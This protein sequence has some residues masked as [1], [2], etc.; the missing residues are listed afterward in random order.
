MSKKKIIG[1]TAAAIVAVI[2]IAAGAIFFLRATPSEARETALVQTGGGSA[3]FQEAQVFYRDSETGMVYLDPADFEEDTVLIKPD[4]SE[5]YALKETKELNGVYNINKGYAVFKQIQI[6]C[7]S[8]EYYI[9]ASG[10]D[11]GLSNYDHIALNGKD[12]Q[13]NDVVF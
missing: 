12:V 11:Y 3:K 9:V 7:E 13:E 2:I 10:S 6:L 1:I 4:S 8:D 5:T